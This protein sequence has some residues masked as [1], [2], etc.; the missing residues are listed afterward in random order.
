[1]MYGTEDMTR[2]EVI[3]WM[4]ANNPCVSQEINGNPY[5][6]SLISIKPITELCLP[7]GWSY[8]GNFITNKG[9]SSSGIS[10]SIEIKF[11]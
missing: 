11:L 1:M 9:R 4:E 6:N 10:H 2:L 3:E 8:E 5:N 7:D